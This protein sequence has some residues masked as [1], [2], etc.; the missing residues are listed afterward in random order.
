MVGSR[1]DVPT[2]QKG[3]S[4]PLD[5]SRL[6]LVGYIVYWSLGNC[7]FAVKSIVGFIRKLNLSETGFKIK[8]V[9]PPSLESDVRG[10]F[11][12]RGGGLRSLEGMGP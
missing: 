6:G 3:Q 10:D 8:K 4:G 7:A 2:P 5:H 1:T 9:L 12:T 11:L